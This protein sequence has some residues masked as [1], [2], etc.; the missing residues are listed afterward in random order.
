MPPLLRS[1]G[2]SAVNSARALDAHNN[3]NHPSN[4][5]P[6]RL[7]ESDTVPSSPTALEK[8]Y[9][10]TQR[11]YNIGISSLPLGGR[12]GTGVDGTVCMDTG[13]GQPVDSIHEGPRQAECSEAVHR[14]SVCVQKDV[15]SMMRIQVCLL[16]LRYYSVSSGT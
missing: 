6:A 5:N 14:G 1:T 15:V 9:K 7:R 2:H 12:S 3:S 13:S 8:R 11:A 10:D 16:R 4:Q